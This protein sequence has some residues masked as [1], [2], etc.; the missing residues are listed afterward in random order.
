MDARYYFTA[1]SRVGITSSKEGT[2][3]KEKKPLVTLFDTK[4]EGDVSHWQH[5]LRI[6][7]IGI[8]KKSIST[9][10]SCNIKQQNYY[11][12]LT[13]QATS[14]SI[15]ILLHGQSSSK[16]TQRE[17]YYGRQHWYPAQHIVGSSASNKTTSLNEGAITTIN[18]NPQTAYCLF[19]CIQ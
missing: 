19:I 6:K 8:S 3:T 2:F 10:N 1:A 16:G 15:G 4:H 14:S 18:W 12:P 7:H 11:Q 17:K 5:N 9:N 13:K